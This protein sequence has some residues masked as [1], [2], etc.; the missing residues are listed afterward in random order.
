MVV[1][2]DLVARVQN[3]FRARL[4][5]IAVPDTK[6]NHAITSI[7]YQ[8]GFIRSIQRGN[9]LQPLPSEPVP[10]AQQ[11]LWLD[12]KY[13]DNK[14]VLSQ[15]SSISTPSK[16]IHLNVEEL[17]LL[18]SGRRAKF[19][20]GLHPGEIAVVSTNKGV[21]ELREAIKR[22]VGGKLLCRAR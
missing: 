13:Q 18:A 8:Q 3:G 12:L 1:F 19:I 10:V 20:E 2:H 15:F 9:H 7:L 4:Q 16:H 5:S 11:R 21:M 22:N 6:M 17:A 14:P